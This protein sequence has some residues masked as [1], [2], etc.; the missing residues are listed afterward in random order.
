MKTDSVLFVSKGTKQNCKQQ[1]MSSLKDTLLQIKHK[2]KDNEADA[3]FL[4]QLEQNLPKTLDSI[5]LP[6]DLFDEHS[7]LLVLTFLASRH[8]GAGRFPILHVANGLLTSPKQSPTSKLAICAVL[9]DW[10][11]LETVLAFL[12]TNVVN[13][14]FGPKTKR[15]VFARVLCKKLF[16][17]PSLFA[18]EVCAELGAEVRLGYLGFLCRKR[19]VFPETAQRVIAAQCLPTRKVL[20][21]PEAFFEAAMTETSSVPTGIKAVNVA[22]KLLAEGKGAR[23]AQRA[24]VCFLQL[25][26][27]ELR[28]TKR[29]VP[30]RFVERTTKKTTRLQTVPEEVRRLVVR[31]AA[32]V[33]LKKRLVPDAVR[34]IDRT[35]CRNF[36][37]SSK[38]EKETGRRKVTEFKELRA[39]NKA[40]A[41]RV[42][43]HL[44]EI[45]PCFSDRKWQVAMLVSLLR[46]FC[47]NHSLQTR[48]RFA[49]HVSRWSAECVEEKKNL[50][51]VVRS[52]LFALGLGFSLPFVGKPLETRVCAKTKSEVFLWRTVFCS[53]DTLVEFLEKLFRKKLGDDAFVLKADVSRIGDLKTCTEKTLSSTE[54]EFVAMLVV[55]TTLANPDLTKFFSSLIQKHS[56]VAL[57]R[58]VVSEAFAVFVAV[59]YF[60]KK[61]SLEKNTKTDTR[62]LLQLRSFSATLAV[63]ATFRVDKQYTLPSLLQLDVKGLF[64]T[65]LC[66]RLVVENVLLPFFVV[67]LE[68][69][70]ASNVLLR[71]SVLVATVLAFFEQAAVLYKDP[72]VFKEHVFRLKRVAKQL[73]FSPRFSFASS[74]GDKNSS[75]SASL[76]SPESL[77]ECLAVVSDNRSIYTQAP[78]FTYRNDVEGLL[79]PLLE[80]KNFANF[81]PFL[82][83]NAEFVLRESFFEW[84]HAS[85]DKLHKKLVGRFERLLRAALLKKTRSPCTRKVC[86]L[87]RVRQAVECWKETGEETTTFFCLKRGNCLSKLCFVP[88]VAT[89]SFVVAKA[90]EVLA[91]QAGLLFET[92][93]PDR[94]SSEQRIVGRRP[95]QKGKEWFLQAIGRVL[96]EVRVHLAAKND[97]NK[98]AVRELGNSDTA[99]NLAKV[100]ARGL[101]QE[102]VGATVAFFETE[103]FGYRVVPEG[104][105]KS[106]TMFLQKVG[107]EVYTE[108][109][110]KVVQLAKSPVFLE[111]LL[112]GCLDLL[113]Q[114]FALLRALEV[115]TEARTQ[116]FVEL[117]LLPAVDF[118]LE[119]CV[120]LEQKAAASQPFRQSFV[121]A[122]FTFLEQLVCFALEPL[123]VWVARQ[124]FTKHYVAVLQRVHTNTFAGFSLEFLHNCGLVDAL[125]LARLTRN[126]SVF[127]LLDLFVLLAVQKPGPFR[128]GFA[129]ST[130]VGKL[131]N[132]CSDRHFAVLLEQTVCRSRSE[133]TAKVLTQL[134]AQHG[135]LCA[136]YEEGLL[137][138]K[139]GTHKTKVEKNPKK[140]PRRKSNES[141]NE[142]GVLTK[143]RNDLLTTVAT[144]QN[145]L[146]ESVFV[147]ETTGMDWLF[148]Q[149]ALFEKEET[150][151]DKHSMDTLRNK[152]S[153]WRKIFFPTCPAENVSERDGLFY[154]P[155]TQSAHKAFL[156][157]SRPPR[158]LANSFTL[159]LRGTVFSHDDAFS[160]F[161]Q[162]TALAKNAV[163]PLRMF[164]EALLCAD[165][166]DRV[167]E[168]KSEGTL[169]FRLV[170]AL[171][172]AVVCCL[173]VV[174]VS[175]SVGL[176]AKRLFKNL[177]VLLAV[178][179][180][181]LDTLVADFPFLDKLVFRR[182]SKLLFLL[183]PSS[184]V[185]LL[186][187]ELTEAEHYA[188]V[189]LKQLTHCLFLDALG[190][191]NNAS[192]PDFTDLQRCLA[193]LFFAEE[194]LS[195]ENCFAPKALVF[196]LVDFVASWDDPPTELLRETTAFF[197]V[198][199]HDMPAFVA[200]HFFP[201]VSRLP[202][203]FL[204][205]QNIL[206]SAGPFTLNNSPLVTT[207]LSELFLVCPF[208]D[209]DNMAAANKAVWQDLES[210]GVSQEYFADLSA[211]VASADEAV[212]FDQ[213]LV[214]LHPLLV[215]TFVNNVDVYH[216]LIGLV[217][218]VKLEY[219]SHVARTGDF[220]AGSCF[221]RS[222]F[223]LGLLAKAT[224][225]LFAV[226][227]FLDPKA[228][229]EVLNASLNLLRYCSFETF[230]MLQ[231]LLQLFLLDTS[232]LV[233]EPLCRTLI[234]RLVKPAPHPWGFLVFFFELK[235][236]PLYGL[237][238]SSFVYTDPVLSGLFDSLETLETKLENTPQPA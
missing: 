189:W 201:L 122:I 151:L 95:A 92:F 49:L 107:S 40:L 63:M 56:S 10:S 188:R 118:L 198:L 59:V 52:V 41:L 221:Y 194:S 16:N 164:A 134:I 103:V 74:F 128:S 70:V 195:D 143:L 234:N 205:L 100:L 231:I 170:D 43:Q 183:A 113:S 185:H 25:L 3:V 36:L 48:L 101:F 32:V 155:R 90:A 54:L 154:C 166:P 219:F 132:G 177:A 110:A 135:A 91:F 19:L 23:V 152:P 168:I 85:F 197:V 61:L 138:C 78:V 208:P 161:A 124:L 233:R 147:A 182:F 213:L 142:D 30:F 148:G 206:A 80:S 96:E 173:T 212:D 217:A 192:P 45:G 77:A 89:D 144:L 178:V 137:E 174:P 123:D 57:E 179:C 109:V 184:L 81:S 126:W 226:L 18:N 28:N 187:C 165:N 6:F 46:L 87:G 232:M 14:E 22:F 9:A 175:A 94:L 38:K 105:D 104:C 106:A 67:F 200:A 13:T 76:H 102:L 58:A 75:T 72:A 47:A 12:L 228:R 53:A 222:E 120:V 235:R 68:Q 20:S 158:V 171:I 71:T 236:N 66:H 230:V 136:V 21:D 215:D 1:T 210:L 157:S 108:G 7:V 214:L 31:A 11:P 162:L 159:L 33:L 37:G 44:D 237:W 51:G 24:L 149:H 150:L 15:F 160:A 139:G 167:V 2:H 220:V 190:E 86:S 199:L 130:A 180:A 39:F 140:K 69:L 65:N 34:L 204:Q 193:A 79:V 225:V 50:V 203:H 224:A 133:T 111:E 117:F 229:T 141:K 116:P 99:S 42:L 112:D 191:S 27:K 88:E 97:Q 17:D 35:I 131:L 8:K 73:G 82:R 145:E 238:T 121:V 60:A 127:G 64:A 84:Q 55:S 129:S 227:F 115:E 153:N 202:S 186:D 196:A 83:S 169:A 181:Q 119:L 156:L 207:D 176:L 211:L 26:Q 29:L 218:R 62:V 114:K 4:F 125:E 5:D 146:D 93:G 98:P 216:L 223:L 172:E 163:A 209:S